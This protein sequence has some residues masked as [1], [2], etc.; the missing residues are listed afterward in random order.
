MSFIQNNVLLIVGILLVL[1]CIEGIIIYVQNVQ[2]KEKPKSKGRIK[3]GVVS[4]EKYSELEE[5]LR[6][7]KSE[8]ERFKK[9]HEDS[10]KKP[11]KQEINRLNQ[12][13]SNL[14]IEKNNLENEIKSLHKSIG[15]MSLEINELKKLTGKEPAPIVVENAERDNST[16]NNS[17]SELYEVSGENT[18]TGSPQTTVQEVDSTE[19]ALEADVPNDESKDESS[20]EESNTKSIKDEPAEEPSKKE[21]KDVSP[22]E[23]TMYA[24]FPRS[25][26]NKIYF[27]DLSDSIVDESY[28]EL[29]ITIASG[30][31]TFKPLDFMKIRNFDPAMVAMCTEGVK[32]N[33]ASIVLGIEH[34]EAHSEGKYWIID[35]LAKIKLA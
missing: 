8:A 1:V 34:G 9:I 20:K 33:V 25:A 12:T 10:L 6:I 30:Q 17:K 22:K 31:A 32:P 28:F 29:R 24:S 35:N 7:A 19:E 13:I 11:D 26:E 2:H 18:E 14:D 23:N 5:K 15:E 4:R 21:S 3:S 16:H 27:S